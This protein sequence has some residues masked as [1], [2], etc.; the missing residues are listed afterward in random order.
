LFEWHAQI[1]AFDAV[2]AAAP[3]RLDVEA[4][5]S[6]DGAFASVSKL[7]CVSLDSPELDDLLPRVS[8]PS[9]SRVVNVPAR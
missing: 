7:K 4:L 8:G 6:G 9:R 1:G 2:L 5:V 3:I